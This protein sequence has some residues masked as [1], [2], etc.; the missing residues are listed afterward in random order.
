M[1]H[2]EIFVMLERFLIELLLF[3]VMLG[4]LE[5]IFLLS[6]SPVSLVETV[7]VFFCKYSDSNKSILKHPVIIIKL[8]KKPI[9][10]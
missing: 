5:L 2:L 1:G 3:F 9:E 6:Q 10:F 4:Q 7:E 8:S